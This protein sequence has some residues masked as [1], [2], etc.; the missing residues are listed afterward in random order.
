MREVEVTVDGQ[1][2]TMI[3]GRSLAGA[4]WAAG[5]RT[6]RSSP[7]DGMPRGAFCMTGVCQEC[8]VRVDGDWVQACRSPVR[9]GMRI[10]LRSPR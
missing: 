1:S 3:E 8:V 7:R 10:A 6:L 5:I 2:R 4:L 9:A